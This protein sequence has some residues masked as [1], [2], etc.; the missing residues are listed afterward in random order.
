M[1]NKLYMDPFTRIYI[2]QRDKIKWNRIHIDSWH[3]RQ[4]LLTFCIRSLSVGNSLD[5]LTIVWLI[6]LNE[7]LPKLQYDRTIVPYKTTLSYF[8]AK[9]NKTE[10][11]SI[12]GIGKEKKISFNLFRVR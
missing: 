5:L 6:G 10:I 7:D 3:D 8:Q 1:A 9:T 12:L 4:F 2:A 11:S